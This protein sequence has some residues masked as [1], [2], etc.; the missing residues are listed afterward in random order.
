MNVR[1]LLTFLLWSI[2]AWL[3][4]RSCSPKE[5]S[6]TEVNLDFHAEDFTD[7]SAEEQTFVL[8]NNLIW[9]KWSSAGASCLEVRLKEF[10]PYLLHDKEATE[11][12]WLYMFRAQRAQP[13][14]EGA[15]G[16]ALNYTKR[17]GL[18][19][20]EAGSDLGTNLES[21]IWTAEVRP[22]ENRIIFR[23]QA[24]NG[25]EIV[26]N[27]QLPDDRYHINLDLE[28]KTL[29]DELTGRDLNLR[30]GTGGGIVKEADT[31]YPN[32]YAAVGVLEYNEVAEFET[33]HPN[34]GLPGNGRRDMVTRWKGELAFVVEGSKYFLNAIRPV[35]S[36]FRGAVAE[37]LYDDGAREEDILKG[38]TQD[39]RRDYRALGR[40][41]QELAAELQ[42]P[43]T[44]AQVAQRLGWEEARVSSI[45]VDLRQRVRAVSLRQGSWYDSD[46]WQR[47]SVAGDFNMHV[48]RVGDFPSQASFEWYIGPKDKAILADYGPLDTIPEFADYGSSFFYRMFL[49]TWIAPGIMALLTFFHSL[50][51]NWG[52]AIIL[53]TILVRI[54]LM[55]LNRRS[56]LKM[57]EYQVKMQKVK[58]LLDSINKKY[59]KDPQAK[60][61]ATMKLYKKHKVAPPLGGCLPPFLQMPIFIGLFAALRSSLKLRQQPFVSWMED[62]SRPDALIDF[63]GPIADF[64][65]LTAVTTFNL[66]PI[67]MVVLWVAHQKSMPKPA[68]PNQAQMQKIM[69]FMPILFGILLY[70]YAAGLS[71]YMITS[72]AIG[73][74]EA[75]VIKKKW[76]VAGS[77]D[78]SETMTG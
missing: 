38:L 17:M 19:L 78:P 5:H 59:A 28:A 36:T 10:T 62:L 66:L 32:P 55:P 71:L 2:I 50:V 25:V 74:F 49:T 68:D 6:P 18:R 64:F 67:I 7:H 51:G 57:A 53:L 73:I 39:D 54:T 15:A 4:F 24:V 45:Q 33:Y 56:Q 69:T 76:P 58:P 3:L 26:K 61:Q 63:G 16:N 46:Y 14:A 23:I 34:G 41:E 20:F 35:G 1:S 12:D 37:V 22:A 13:P 44:P 48:S 42:Q 72:S 40:A 77:D 30:L 8:E 52:V 27:I 65:P 70:N 43:A 11:S 29:T 47:T 9:T 75:K 31:F 21:D 60:Q